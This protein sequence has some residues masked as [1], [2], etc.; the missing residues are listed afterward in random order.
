MSRVNASVDAEILA[1]NANEIIK[2]DSR[3]TVPE[4]CNMTPASVSKYKTGVGLQYRINLD[5][6]IPE[7]S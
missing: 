6:S 3:I 5:K 2:N 1:Y 7:Y 4:E